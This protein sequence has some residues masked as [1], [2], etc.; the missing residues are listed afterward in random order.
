[1]EYKKVIYEDFNHD[2]FKFK[3]V[4]DS[5]LEDSPLKDTIYKDLETL[6]ARV[7]VYLKRDLANKEFRLKQEYRQNQINKAT[8]N[9]D[10]HL[11][12]FIETLSDTLQNE[13][14]KAY[15]KSDIKLKYSCLKDIYRNLKNYQQ[16][17]FLKEY[18]YKAF[19]ASETKTYKAKLENGTYYDIKKSEYIYLKYLEDKNVLNTLENI[20][21]VAKA[22][23]IDVL[24]IQL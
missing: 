7:D 10:K 1:M 5:V 24:K 11:N 2:G 9:Q 15:L 6:K 16:I 13:K 3:V 20:K 21:N 17:E 14:L 12:G 8:E 4:N 23:E 19:Y 22:K 18:G